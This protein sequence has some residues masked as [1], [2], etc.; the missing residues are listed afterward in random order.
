[1]PVAPLREGVLFPGMQTE[2]KFGREL[3][4][5]AI[6]A[7]A[8][9]DSLVFI[10]SQIRPDIDEPAP[11]DLHAVGILARIGQIVHQTKDNSYNVTVTALHRAKVLEWT[12]MRDHAQFAKIQVLEDDYDIS[13]NQMEV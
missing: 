13:R 3:S 6:R 1:M 5:A 10:T 9:T 12:D 7:S 2:M 4:R 8:Q 11:K